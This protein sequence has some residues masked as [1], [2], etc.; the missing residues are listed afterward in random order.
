MFHAN[1]WRERTSLFLKILWP[2]MV[3]QV[4]LYLMT[5]TDT[6]LAGQVGTD[7]LAGVAIGS[8]LW[9]PIITGI[10]GILMA[11]SP[12]VAQLV[13]K[14]KR[15]EIAKSV[16]QSLYLSVVLALVVAGT[17]AVALGPILSGMNVS[18]NV[19]HIAY[20][21][22]IGLLIG[23]V[24]LFAS[25]AL[26]YFFDAQGYTRISMIIILIAIPFNALFNY[27][28]IFGKFGLPALGGIGSGYATAITYWIVFAMSVWMTFKVQAIRGFRL[29]VQWAKPS[30]KAWK[31]LMAI[32]VP[33]GM[34][35]FF[36][37]SIFSVVTLMMGMQYSTETI[38]AHQSA[39]SFTSLVFMIPLSIS[40]ALTI[41]VGYSVGGR[42][43]HAA[44]RYTFMG[45]WGSVGFLAICSVFMYVFREPIA[46]MYTNEPEVA[47]LAIQFLLVSIFYQLS[48]AIQSSLQGVLRGYK[49]VQV[50]FI[51][52]FVSYWIIGIPSGYVL[53]TYTELGPFGY[54]IGIIIGLTGSAIGFWIRLSTILRSS[55]VAKTAAVSS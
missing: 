47:N 24:P 42:R 15:D 37:V 29:F 30:L 53:S 41:V 32:G 35:I 40:M 49:D 38:A 11:I 8:S 19:E 28:L 3:A 4:G 17:V 44:R 27:I 52:T 45:V 10:N 5:L 22:V 50:P 26:R 2:I 9:V 43:F 20:H 39:I 25:N 55:T 46:Y 34:A 54:W 33:I 36:E 1:N 21:Y 18:D 31:E 51:I 12:I 7:D 16:T 48:D 23:I 13:G 14:G 6:I